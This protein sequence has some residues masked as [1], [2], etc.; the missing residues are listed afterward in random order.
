MKFF[1]LSLDGDRHGEGWSSTEEDEEGFRSLPQTDQGKN[2]EGYRRS[3]G[4]SF[5]YLLLSLFLSLFI[6]L[7]TDLG[8]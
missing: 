8:S 3:L 4:G 1:S 6:L 2:D 5:C 7:Q